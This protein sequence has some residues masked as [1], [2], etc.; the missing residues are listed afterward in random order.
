MLPNKRPRQGGGT[1]P[2]PYNIKKIN[3]K[4]VI[5]YGVEE[6]TFKAKFNDDISRSKIS[7]FKDDLHGMFDEILNQAS[8]NYQD[9]DKMRMS[10][11]HRSLDKPITIHL[12]PRGN[13]TADVIMAR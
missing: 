9:G 6:C 12:Q 8:E 1:P 10:I 11:E 5:K 4:R 7:E 3:E 2:K 13:I